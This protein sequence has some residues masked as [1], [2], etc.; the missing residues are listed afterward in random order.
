M[1]EGY[2]QIL[3]ESLEK[4]IIVL[5]QIIELDKQQAEISAHQPMD[6]EAYDEVVEE[7]NKLDDGFS[8][9]YE[10]IGDEVKNH[11]QQYREQVQKLQELIRDAV[12]KGVTIEA[13]EKRN[14]AAL[15]TVF[16]MKRQEIRQMKV[17][18]SA[19][20]KYYKNMSRINNIDP[21][22]MDKKK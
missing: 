7:I 21:Q 1:P 20:S 13:Q 18:T 10:L 16:R 2:L 9:T 6:M 11:P 12:D 15:D 17:S 3:I 19:A 14:K 8:S 5:D 4:K 22:L